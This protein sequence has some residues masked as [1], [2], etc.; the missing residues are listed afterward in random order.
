MPDNGEHD[1]FETLIPDFSAGRTP[2]ELRNLV[3]DV[4]L[5]ASI[6]I[7]VANMLFFH[8]N[9]LAF[10]GIG[11]VLGSWYFRLPR[12]VRHFEPRDDDETPPSV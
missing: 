6:P 7:V 12:S 11:L 5:Y 4:F 1:Q 8:Y 10:T 3:A 2:D 9:G